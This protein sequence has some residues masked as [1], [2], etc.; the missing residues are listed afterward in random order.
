MS[1]PQWY[2]P[3]LLQYSMLMHQLL[4]TDM[5]PLLDICQK[6]QALAW[7]SGAAEQ[8][9]GCSLGLPDDLALETAPQGTIP[10]R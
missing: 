4:E 8:L 10:T 9:V 1:H 3:T 5:S 2:G 6:T 7:E